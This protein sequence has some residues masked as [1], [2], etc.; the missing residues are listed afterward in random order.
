[1]EVF[2]LANSSMDNT[3]IAGEGREEFLWLRV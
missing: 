1:M 2:L 3:K